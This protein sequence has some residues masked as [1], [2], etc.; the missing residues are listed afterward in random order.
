MNNIYKIDLTALADGKE[1]KII[2]PTTSDVQ[3][4]APKNTNPMNM[5][6]M[7]MGG[8]QPDANFFA[9]QKV[10]MRMQTEIKSGKIYLFKSKPKFI[11]WAKLC[12]SLVFA[13]SFL[14]ALFLGV[15]LI[16]VNGNISNNVLYD[17]GDSSGGSYL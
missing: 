13:L 5:M 8:N 4:A 6:S 7:M 1:S 11:P 3:Q 14:S 17:G 12:L 9:M 15:A 16:V 10:N 2:A